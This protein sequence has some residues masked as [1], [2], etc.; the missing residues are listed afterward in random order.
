[1]EVLPD[2]TNAGKQQEEPWHSLL[3]LFNLKPQNDIGSK[4]GPHSGVWGGGA[5][6]MVTSS[7]IL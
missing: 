1:M 3:N 7:V 6:V 5:K 2:K 4:I